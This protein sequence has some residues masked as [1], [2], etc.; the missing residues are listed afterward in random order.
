MK[1]SLL[2]VVL[3]VC[4]SCTGNSATKLNSPPDTIYFVDT[5]GLDSL[6]QSLVFEKGGCLTGGQYVKDGHFGG[7]GCV[8][9]QHRKGRPDWRPFFRNPKKDLTEFLISQ[10][11]DTSTTHIHTCP[12]AIAK[13]GEVAV[14]CL[15]KIYLVNWYDFEPFL[16]YQNREMTDSTDCPQTWLQAILED[17]KKRELLIAEWRKL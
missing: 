13:A 8:L 16:E 7:E 14:Y 17:P 3:L 5:L 11:T 4:F 9:T 1:R 15:S 2:F 12:F 10:F 6:W